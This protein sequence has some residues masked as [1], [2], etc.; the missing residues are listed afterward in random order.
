MS[1]DLRTGEITDAPSYAEPEGAFEA[2][3]QV[4]SKGR[5]KVWARYI[6]GNAS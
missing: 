5:A 1:V 3:G 4:I 2:R 6:G